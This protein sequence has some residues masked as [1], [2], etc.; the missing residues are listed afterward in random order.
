MDPTT[1]TLILAG[2]TVVLAASTTWMAH[3]TKEVAGEAKEQTA[4]TRRALEL[5]EEQLRLTRRAA[6]AS[7]G[8][9]LEAAR[10]RIDQRAHRLV[11][12]PGVPDWP[13][14]R[15]LPENDQSTK[16]DVGTEF[17]LPRDA[18]TR[19]W[20]RSVFLLRNDGA[21]TAICYTQGGN[22]SDRVAVHSGPGTFR[23]LS[24]E[25]VVE[26]PKVSQDRYVLLSG[27]SARIVFDSWRTVDDRVTAWNE[28]ASSPEPSKMRLVFIVYDPHFAATDNMTFVV[29]T[30]PLTPVAHVDGHWEVAPVEQPDGIRS[31]DV[32]IEGPAQRSY[33]G[34][35]EYPAN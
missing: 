17:A 1:A 35:H 23:D 19:L 24:D 31:I 18:N 29:Q 3:A 30:Y 25:E 8:Q 4:A 26:P 22:H 33:P 12:I 6:E 14:F 10:S 7:E 34:L 32:G 5:N 16:F 13:P 11:V 15:D 9:A 2:I 21:S 28:R 27:Q 20:F